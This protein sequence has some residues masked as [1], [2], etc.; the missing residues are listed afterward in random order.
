MPTPHAMTARLAA[1]LQHKLVYSRCCLAGGDCQCSHSRAR[2]DASYASLPPEFVS[3]CI[4]HESVFGRN[5]DR[6]FGVKIQDLQVA[7][8][9]VPGRAHA[10]LYV[11]CAH[12]LAFALPSQALWLCDAQ[13]ARK[14]EMARKIAARWMPVGLLQMPLAGP[15]P[16]QDAGYGV[17]YVAP[18]P[19]EGGGGGVGAV[20]QKRRYILSRHDVGKWVAIT[21]HWKLRA[22]CKGWCAA[23]AS[24]RL[25][26]ASDAFSDAACVRAQDPAQFTPSFASTCAGKPSAC[27]SP[28][29]TTTT[30]P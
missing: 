6:L 23:R 18:L 29:V 9:R 7:A 1:L 11:A 21:Q 14:A 15:P 28:R 8:N 5:F 25:L 27:K 22:G 2:C 24:R 3:A 16:V 19:A 13:P 30:T 12:V 26:R 10:C 17:Q 20:P 4:D